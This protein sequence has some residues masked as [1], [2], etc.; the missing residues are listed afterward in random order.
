MIQKSIILTRKE[1]EVI[2]KKLK[3]KK[4]NQQ[5]SNYLSRY[6]RPKLREISLLDSKLLLQKLEYNQKQSSI[7]KKIEKIILSNLKD[8]VSITLYGSIVYNNYKNYN[9]IDILVVVKKKFWKILGEKYKNIIEIKEKAKKLGL[10]LDLQIYDL[11]TIYNS[12]SSSLDLIYQLKDSKTI[13][14]IL[15]LPKKIEIPKLSLR[16][17]L[18]YSIITKDTPI[19]EIYLAIRNLWLI[20]LAV[21]RII[22]NSILLKTLDHE[23]GGNLVNRIKNNKAYQIDK[24]IALIYLESL[25]NKTIKELNNSKWEKIVL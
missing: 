9:D 14:G 20:K 22:D 11:E 24:K 3:N 2:D 5:D 17:K 7:D 16:M 15:N 10:K 12:Y 21:N 6:V 23:L 18:D 8:V 19:N 1:L 25:L 13:Y 4:L